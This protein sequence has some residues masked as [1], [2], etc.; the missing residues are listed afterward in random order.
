MTVVLEIFVQ[1]ILPIFILISLGFG[2]S[3]KFPVDINTLTK[4]NFFLF[5]PSFTFVNLYQTAIGVDS[6][7]ALAIALLILLANLMLGWLIARV[8]RMSSGMAVAFQNS[9]A[10]YN[11]G[12]IGIPLIT[13][14]YSTGALSSGG[15]NPY[16]D[17]ALA[18]QVMVLL[19]QNLSINTLGFF[20]AGSTNR[21]WRDSLRTIFHMPT[22]YTVPL[23]FL[24]KAAPFDLAQTP[25]WVVLTYL[26]N[27][28][29]PIALLTLGVQLA[30]T[31]KLHRITGDAWLATFSRLV[32]GPV[33]VFGLIHL[34][35]LTGVVAQTLFISTAVPT[36]VNS[37][38][39]AVECKNHPDF[40]AQVV[41]VTTLLSA[42]SLIAV[43]YAAQILFP[44]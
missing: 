7:K 10:Y 26:K 37:A 19:V 40:A 33:L 20:S 15:S 18:T 29:V 13:L 22:V 25:I 2:L 39:I 16:L 27:A 14:V 28:L 5:V 17:V 36:A 43:I 30:R 42:L 32:L 4:F 3:R 34:F 35:G 24:L 41:M 8:R 6:L 44:V 9:V 21:H 23:A 38:L 12:N 31:R 1:N 11:S